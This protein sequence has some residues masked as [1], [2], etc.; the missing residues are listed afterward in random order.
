MGNKAQG[1][2]QKFVVTRTDGSSEVGGKHHDCDY[3]VLDMTHDKF[4]AAAIKAYADAC[5]AEYPLLALD[6][7]MKYSAVIQPTTSTHVSWP[8]S[9]DVG[10]ME[11]MSPN[12]F[13][14][15]GLDSDGDVYVHVC[16]EE[17]QASVEFCT[18]T[19]GGGKSSKTRMALIA[20]M[21][22]IEADN[23]ENPLFD[24]WARRNTKNPTAVQQENKS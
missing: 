22:A 13:L 9:N 6:L 4:A 18:S 12:G 3:F 2:Y 5:D 14:R 24:W 7:R 8:K 19:T 16:D 20:L 1:L 23:A 10:R 15:V 21:V 17:S 11:D